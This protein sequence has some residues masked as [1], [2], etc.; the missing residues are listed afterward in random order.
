ML[1]LSGLYPDLNF[2]TTVQYAGPYAQISGSG[3]RIILNGNMVMLTTEAARHFA[4]CLDLSEPES[5]GRILD[6]IDRYR[7]FRSIQSQI[8]GVAQLG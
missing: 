1:E 4:P 3:I 8:R 2:N 5:F 6:W 7:H